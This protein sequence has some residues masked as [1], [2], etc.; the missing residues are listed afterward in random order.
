MR[1][2]PDDMNQLLLVMLLLSPQSCCQNLD[3][4]IPAPLVLMSSLIDLTLTRATKAQWDK[5]HE[6]Q[7]STC[8]YY[9]ALL[10]ASKRG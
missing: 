5:T 8:K 4:F 1:N 6:I 9:Q 3:I 2:R 10:T 7:V